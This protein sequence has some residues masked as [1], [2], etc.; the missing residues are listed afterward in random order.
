M[1]EDDLHLDRIDLSS[2]PFAEAAFRSIEDI[3]RANTP[4]LDFTNATRVDTHSENL[5]HR[6]SSSFWNLIE[7][8][9]QLTAN[10]STRCRISI[11]LSSPIQAA[12]R[13]LLGM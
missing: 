5:G 12:G 10:Q 4:E 6:G 7:Q 2:L 9:Y 3:S 1:Q 11:T 8:L 13:L